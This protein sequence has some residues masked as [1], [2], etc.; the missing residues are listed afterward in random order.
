MGNLASSSSSSSYHTVSLEND[1]TLNVSSSDSSSENHR[2]L[3]IDDSIYHYEQS[4]P[5]TT[6]VPSFLPLPF[7]LSAPTS[8]SVA[9]S[10]DC[11]YHSAGKNNNKNKNDH[12]RHF[13][14]VGYSDGI[15]SLFNLDDPIKSGE[16]SIKNYLISIEKNNG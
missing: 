8:S 6:I 3:A 4:H 5:Q 2:F 16:E 11:Y 13:C 1:L 14:A 15:I 10:T 7:Q 9:T 12:R